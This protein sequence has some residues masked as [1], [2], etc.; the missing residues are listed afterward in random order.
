MSE[1][2][3]VKDTISGNSV[4]TSFEE[5]DVST[6]FSGAVVICS[7]P[8][9]IEDGVNGGASAISEPRVNC[10]GARPTV[11]DVSMI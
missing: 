10:L 7:G 5:V 2:L 4:V 9:H 3:V 11:L 8:I 6:I 1:Q